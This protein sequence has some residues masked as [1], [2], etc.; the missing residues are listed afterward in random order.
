MSSRAAFRSRD[1]RREY[2]HPARRVTAFYCTAGT[3]IPAICA[4]CCKRCQARDEAENY[5]FWLP[6]FPTHF[7]PFD[8]TARAL[9]RVLA[10][11]QSDGAQVLAAQ[12]SDWENTILVGYSMG[13]LI[14]R[15]MV[16]DGFPCRAVVTIC[17]PHDG[18]M[19]WVPRLSAGPRSLGKR[20]P[21][22][23]A[24]NANPRDIA[25]HRD[26]HFFGV[27]YRDRFGFH[28]DDAVVPRASALG[29]K[30]GEIGTRR[31]IELDYERGFGRSTRSNPH[32][33][34]LNPRTMAPMIDL[35]AQLFAAE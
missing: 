33:E 32:V 29:E 9:S 27:T 24:L 18:P 8:D 22:M 16:A 31:A 2:S 11:Q 13:G 1:L 3:A 35:C 30:L 28:D 15:Q 23:R 14:A 12:Q 20:A 34:G 6:D 17:A 26:Y 25:R 7:R 21:Q 10:T 19:F 4:R 5:T